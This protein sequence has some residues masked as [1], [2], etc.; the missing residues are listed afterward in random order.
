MRER[1]IFGKRTKHNFLLYKDK[2]KDV[3]GVVGD[4]CESRRLDK[5]ITTAINSEDEL[6]GDSDESRKFDN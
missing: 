2:L 6:K 3:F 4:T 1:K 5:F